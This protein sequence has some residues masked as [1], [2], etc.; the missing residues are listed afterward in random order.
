MRLVWRRT[1]WG[2]RKRETARVIRGGGGA[3]GRVED[4]LLFLEM[5][6]GQASNVSDGR[7]Y[8]RNRFR[9]G[10]PQRGQRESLSAD[11][12]DGDNH[13]QR[14]ASIE[15]CP[16]IDPIPALGSRNR[17]RIFDDC[18][19]HHQVGL[20]FHAVFHPSLRDGSIPDTCRSSSAATLS[21]PSCTSRPS[22]RSTVSNLSVSSCWSAGVRTLP[23]SGNSR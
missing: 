18:K 16:Y 7:L 14:R 8:F 23:A 3:G 12:P 2:L 4:D 19:E 20:G 17:S 22:S 21:N 10:T 11:A 13:T 1:K 5:N 15:G 9:A 6:R